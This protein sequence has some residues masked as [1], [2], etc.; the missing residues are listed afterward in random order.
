M[1]DLPYLI[2][3]EELEFLILQKCREQEDSF[4]FVDD[5]MAIIRRLAESAECMQITI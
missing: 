1:I 2:D 5:V 3:R 4:L